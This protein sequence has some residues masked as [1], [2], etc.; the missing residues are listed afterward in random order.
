[1]KCLEGWRVDTIRYHSPHDNP[2]PPP[3]PECY[4]RVYPLRMTSLRVVQYVDLCYSDQREQIPCTLVQYAIHCTVVINVLFRPR[5][6]AFQ[7]HGFLVKAYMSVIMLK[8]KSVY[9]HLK[10]TL[11]IPPNGYRF[12]IQIF[13]SGGFRCFICHGRVRLF[14]VNILIKSSVG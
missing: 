5:I 2:P 7:G 8:T 11:F 13:H 3:P 12:R 10:C 14:I 9:R 1:M 4:T 6:E